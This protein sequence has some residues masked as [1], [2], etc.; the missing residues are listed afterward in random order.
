MRWN[1][2]GAVAPAALVDSRLALHHAAQVVASAGVTFL[3]PQPDDSHPNL[4]WA[5]PLGALVGRTLPGANV[6]I[7]LRLSDLT[8]L[9]VDR[10][11][12]VRD[13]LALHGKTL[14]DGYVWLA[15]ATANAGAEFPAQGITR[16][17]YEFPRH[18]T[19][20]GAVF[21]SE[22]PDALAELARWFAT[23]FEVLRALAAQMPGASEVRCWPHHFDVGALVSLETQPDGSLAKSIGLGLSPGDQSYAEPYWY[24]SPWPY[25]APDQ[26]PALENGGHWHTEGFAAAILTGSELISG[27]P[28]SQSERVNAFLDN[29]VAASRHALAG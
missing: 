5:E 23:G 12:D 21:S 19:S 9:L 2:L 10:N 24:V 18:A 4:G 3:K 13:A 6:Q 29:A 8:L 20:E 7:G 16:S 26:L 1:D 27:P 17:S 15:E 22:S 14:E 25:P 11:G 28:D